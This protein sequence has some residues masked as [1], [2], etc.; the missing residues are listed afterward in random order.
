M[1]T[2]QVRK[3]ED[4][5]KQESE[6]DPNQKC[7]VTIY[8]A[9]RNTW[10]TEKGSKQAF[11]KVKRLGFKEEKEEQKEE[12][13]PRLQFKKQK[14]LGQYLLNQA[15][16]HPQPRNLSEFAVL[17]ITGYRGKFMDTTWA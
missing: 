2:F 12:L 1:V 4:E 8:L 13:Q 5:L 6:E 14:D 16:H 10:T 3:T 17:N 9:K 15:S 7:Q 11:K